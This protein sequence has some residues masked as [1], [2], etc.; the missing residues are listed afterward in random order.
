VRQRCVRVA[1]VTRTTIA[2]GGVAVHVARS[3]DAL[4]AHGCPVVVIAGSAPAGADAVIVP[5]LEGGVVSDAGLEQLTSIVTASD[6]EVVHFH[7]V[8]APAAV[9]AL[10]AHALTVVSAHGW[11]GCAPNKNYFGT[12]RE[13]T[14]AHGPVCIGNMLFRNCTHE[15]DPRPIAGYYRE[16]S[17]RLEA[18]GA[19]HLAVAY[20]TAVR[21]HLERNGLRGVRRVSLPVNIP[22]APSGASARSPRV[23]FVGRVSPE[24]GVDVLLR[25][26][27]HF[28]AAVDIYGD[29]WA[30]PR[31]ERTAARLGLGERVRFHGWCDA[32]TVA[33]AYAAASVAVVPSRWPEPF[34]MVG[35]EAM[36][37]ATPVVASASGGIADWLEH[38][39]TGLM[40]AP[41]DPQ[42]L[43]QAIARLLANPDDARAMGA[44]ARELVESRFSVEA[45]VDSLL[46]A[47]HDGL[48]AHR[49]SERR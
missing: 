46:G 27:R 3:A 36:A 30:R 32:R 25:S 26:A 42:A 9:R 39:R 15:R 2:D 43:G 48:L 31:L 11:P 4:Q 49:R 1:L 35:P 23:V 44:A 12:G 45:H 24:K 19:A 6:A 37:H 16:A 17:V 33:A 47:Y 14:R 38:E 8:E 20:S 34:G 22:Q 13:C 28:D 41:G 7:S 21:R 40:V 29:G 10:R 18:L 5:E